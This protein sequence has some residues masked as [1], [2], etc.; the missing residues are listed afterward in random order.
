MSANNDWN[1]AF[2]LLDQMAEMQRKHLLECAQEIIP[3]ITEEDLLQPNDFIELENHP[4]FRYEEGLL[5]G[6]QSVQMA[7]QNEYASSH[8]P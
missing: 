1:R 3:N 6:I 4:V 5:A 8:N 2:L 7:L